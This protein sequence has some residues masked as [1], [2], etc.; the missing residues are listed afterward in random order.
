M[1]RMEVRRDPCTFGKVQWARLGR[2]SPCTGDR[3][4]R[5]RRYQPFGGIEA[6]R[7]KAVRP[8]EGEDPA[9]Y[10]QARQR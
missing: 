5:G 2:R 4:V 10:P 1:D 3:R 6:G 8:G 9:Q 7:H